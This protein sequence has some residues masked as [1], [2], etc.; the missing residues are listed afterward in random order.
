[1]QMISLGIVLMLQLAPHQATAIAPAS[2][3]FQLETASA[4]VSDELPSASEA[5]ILAAMEAD[6]IPAM[7]VAVYKDGQIIAAKAYGFEDLE[8]GNPA[9]IDT[10]FRIGSVAKVFTATLAA[11]LAHEGKLDLDRPVG[12]YVAAWPKEHPPITI[13]QLLGHL[14]GV[15]H[16]QGKDFD[17]GGPGGA[18][19]LR[20]YPNNDAILAL[21]K[22]DDLIA[23]PGER[24]SYTTFG[25]SLIGIAMEEATGTPFDQLLEQYVLAPGELHDVAI[26]H[27]FAIVKNRASPYDPA[28]DY[29]ELVPASA[30]PVVNS[31]PLNS[32]YKVPGGG[33]VSDAETLARFGALHFEPGFVEPALYQQMFTSQKGAD[34]KE[35][36][37]GLGWRIATDASGRTYYH[38]SGSQ[39]G[40][41][42]HLS[43]YPDQ[44]ISVAILSN[45]A[46][47]PRDIAALSTIIAADFLE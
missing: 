32:A 17:F 34:G 15:R 5:A 25:Y 18:I 43:V 9:T 2:A 4:R 27:L 40:S 13:R 35:T 28:S 20:A 36:G 14:G 39:Q 12:D 3:T 46:N 29:G 26:D 33:L 47:K 7:S 16:Y 6:H 21:F 22:D 45:L 38:H 37:T 8:K 44:Q 23:A 42:A 41:R 11:R 10:R 30:G 24:F 19:D 31:M 1:M